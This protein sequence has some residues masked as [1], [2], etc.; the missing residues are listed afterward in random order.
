MEK[1]T[2]EQILNAGIPEIHYECYPAFCELILEEGRTQAISEFKEKLIKRLWKH[3][4]VFEG[5]KCKTSL[6]LDY[7]EAEIEKTA[8]EIK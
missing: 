7:V 3:K 4:K 6:A 5:D 2:K 1:Q 8:Q